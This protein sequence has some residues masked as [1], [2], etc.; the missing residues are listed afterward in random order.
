[1]SAVDDANQR[2]EAALSRLEVALQSRLAAQ[3][4]GAT[5]EREQLEQE[6]AA[7]RAQFATLKESSAAVSQRL[8][9]AIGQLKSVLAE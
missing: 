6:M 8:D 7:G 9:A 3:D 5:S 4:S 2:L 1:M